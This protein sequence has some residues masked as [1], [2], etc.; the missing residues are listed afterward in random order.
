MYLRIQLKYFTPNQDIYTPCFDLQV[1]FLS[2]CLVMKNLDHL[3]FKVKQ[4]DK[5]CIDQMSKFGLLYPFLV[6]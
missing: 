3:L 6:I 4:K 1:S 2:F 5:R